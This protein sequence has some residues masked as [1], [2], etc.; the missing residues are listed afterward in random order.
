[1]VCPEDTPELAVL[2][3]AV[4]DSADDSAADAAAVCRRLIVDSLEDDDLSLS[5]L[6]HL[7]V[8]RSHFYDI[9]N[10]YH[11]LLI[12]CFTGELIDLEAPGSHTAPKPPVAS[13]LKLVQLG[14][15]LHMLDKKSDLLHSRT[16]ATALLCDVIDIWTHDQCRPAAACSLGDADELLQPLLAAA[17]A[18]SPGADSAVPDAAVSLFAASAADDD[19]CSELSVIYAD[20]FVPEIWEVCSHMEDGRIIARPARAALQVAALLDVESDMI[21]PVLTKSTSFTDVVLNFIDKAFTVPSRIILVLNSLD[22]TCSAEVLD[23]IAKTFVELYQVRVR[24]RWLSIVQRAQS[25]AGLFDRC[26]F[27]DLLRDR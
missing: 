18:C 14:S 16:N 26:S 27:A 23:S 8:Q 20:N 24:R 9:I 22:K 1:M 25:N 7:D 5:A 21:I 4:L 15:D 6:A 2:P 19:V 11:D 10:R 17:A 13:H 12:E 3:A